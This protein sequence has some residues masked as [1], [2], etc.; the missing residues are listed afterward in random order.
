M[1]CSC[2]RSDVAALRVL[3]AKSKVVECGSCGARGSVR[4]WVA[5]L[6]APMLLFFVFPVAPLPSNGWLSTGLVV[7]TVVVAYV[8]AYWAFVR[9][10]W[11]NA[12]EDACP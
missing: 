4:G 3:A 1:K 10:I 2:C 9:V 8:L 6:V 12:T 7:L 5:F 11:T